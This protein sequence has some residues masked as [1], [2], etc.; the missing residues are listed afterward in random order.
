LLRPAE[1]TE[2]TTVFDADELRGLWLAAEY[3][4]GFALAQLVN[5]VML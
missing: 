5:V 3:P 1:I 2:E 4:T